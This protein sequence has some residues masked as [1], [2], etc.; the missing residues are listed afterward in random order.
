[1]SFYN[2]YIEALSEDVIY[3]LWGNGDIDESDINIE[4][5]K[6]KKDIREKI[7]DIALN[8]GIIIIYDLEE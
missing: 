3:N 2:D 8:K 6:I 4:I 5:E 7:D 1:M